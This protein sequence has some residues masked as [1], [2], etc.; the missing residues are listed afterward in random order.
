LSKRRL[1]AA[2]PHPIQSCPIGRIHPDSFRMRGDI[3]PQKNTEN[4]KDQDV[5]FLCD[6]CVLLRPFS[7]VSDLCSFGRI[8]PDS[9]GFKCRREKPGPPIL[10]FHFSFFILPSATKPPLVNRIDHPPSLAPHNSL[11]TFTASFACKPHPGAHSP[12][13]IP[14]LPNPPWNLPASPTPTSC[15]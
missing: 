3:Q 15:N 2:I 5:S 4:T 1:F 7:A 9:V 13:R 11:S 14:S 8:H 10:I 6:P 12:H